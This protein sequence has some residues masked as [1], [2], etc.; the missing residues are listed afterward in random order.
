MGNWIVALLFALLPAFAVGAEG[1]ARLERFLADLQTLRADFEQQLFDEY[2][3]PLET[4]TGRVRLARPDR[5]AWEYL[6]PYRQTIVSNGKELWVYDEDL[7]QVTINPIEGQNAA[8]PAH[9][10]SGNV[11]LAAEYE[12]EELGERD[13]ATWVR[14]TP[15]VAN[16]QY[17][18][19]ELGLTGEEV[20]AMRL[21]DNLGQVT[22]LRF[23]RI[24]RNAPI[25]PASF[26]F[27]PP[28]GVDIVHGAAD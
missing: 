22:E 1:A 12:T 19:I 20:T 26:D 7:A 9:L 21:Q 11:D 28:A 14:L 4:S 24:E 13:G 27:E 8:T 16:Q 2:G 25:D 10:L 3:A 5:F 23:T 6:E 18:G 17:D 15:R